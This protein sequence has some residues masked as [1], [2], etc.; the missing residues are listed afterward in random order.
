VADVVPELSELTIV[1]YLRGLHA[2]GRTE[3]E[4]AVRLS[5][6][7]GMAFK[8]AWILPYMLGAVADARQTMNGR[9]SAESLPWWS[10]VLPHIVAAGAQAR[11]L[12]RA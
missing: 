2:V 10:Q 7:A 9:P 3:D 4:R 11:D 1:G 8:Y 12:A 6:A 5:V